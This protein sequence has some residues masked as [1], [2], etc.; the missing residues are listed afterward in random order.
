[1]NN[2]MLETSCINR[3]YPEI[4]FDI[5]NTLL[6][7]TNYWQIL[8]TTASHSNELMCTSLLNVKSFSK[9]WLLQ[10]ILL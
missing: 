9:H 6:G 2:F 1:M 4:L 5:V 3:I 7:H 10:I 8:I